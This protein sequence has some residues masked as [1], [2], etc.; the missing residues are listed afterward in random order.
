MYFYLAPIGE[1]PLAV[2]HN[3]CFFAGLAWYVSMCLLVVVVFFSFIVCLLRCFAFVCLLRTRFDTQQTLCER[4]D[5]ESAVP[6]LHHTK[7]P[8]AC[9]TAT[10]E[11]KAGQLRI[12]ARVWCN[13]RESLSTIHDPQRDGRDI[14]KARSIKHCL[15][16]QPGPCFL[17]RSRSQCHTSASAVQ[18]I[19]PRCLQKRSDLAQQTERNCRSDAELAECECKSACART[20]VVSWA[21]RHWP[22]WRS[23]IPAGGRFTTRATSNTSGRFDKSG[24][25]RSRWTDLRLL[26]PAYHR[27]GCLRELMGRSIILVPFLSATVECEKQAI[28]R[29]KIKYLLILC[30][31][32]LHCWFIITARPVFLH[33][34]IY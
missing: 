22:S 31:V 14:Q 21:T 9:S 23:E 1:A 18:K 27:S 3:V 16:L 10:P 15:W 25:G 33:F 32:H 24:S 7:T 13:L 34:M 17:P 6:V 2:I 12:G 30:P 5:D 20:A 28:F 19:N 29:G 8:R 11:V 4:Y 26:A